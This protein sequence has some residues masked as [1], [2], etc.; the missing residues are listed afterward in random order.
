MRVVC[1]Q[2][3]APGDWDRRMVAA[4]AAAG[5]CQTTY[6]ARVIEQIDQARPLFIEVCVNESHTPVLSLLLFQKIPWDRH[7]QRRSYRALLLTAWSAWLEWLDGPVV[8]SDN[9]VDVVEAFAVLL[10]WAR[11]FAKTNGLSGVRA[12]GVPRT[13]KWTANQ[14][15][16]A[17]FV[18]H[19][20]FSSPWGTYLTDLTLEEEVLWQ[21]LHPSARKNVNRARALRASVRRIDSFDE[22][23]ARFHHPYCR[24]ESAAGRR[25]G[26]L[27]VAAAM[28]R[29]DQRSYYRYYVAD[30]ADGETLATLGM[31]L[32]NGVA[33]EIASALSPRAFEHK[34]PAQDLLH[35]EMLLEAK[36]A[37]CHTFD[38]AGVDPSATDSKATGIRRFKEKWG[39]RYVE[40]RRYELELPSV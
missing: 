30:S 20:Y 29:E 6:W 13:S 27:S 31:H 15:L 37:G 35:W 5:L 2:D 17:L 14:R 40:Y 4:G 24:I 18:E 34:I 1:H 12:L 22:Y 25:P 11:D 23:V 28:R 8:H 39:G 36:R 10:A 16:D 21:R 7:K 38:V 9:E 26:P 32:F 19:G 33:T 3:G